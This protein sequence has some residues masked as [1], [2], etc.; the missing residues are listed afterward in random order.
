MNVD[1][2]CNRESRRVIRG[3]IMEYRL[4]EDDGSGKG[5]KH[6]QVC[7]NTG[8]NVLIELDAFNAIVRFLE[9]ERGNGDV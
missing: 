8:Y 5:F 9:E 7:L 3:D 6:V 1:V 4:V 2:Y